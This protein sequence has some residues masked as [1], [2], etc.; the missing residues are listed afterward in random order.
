[1]LHVLKDCRATRQAPPVY[2]SSS[3]YGGN[4]KI[5]VAVEDG[6]DH[7]VSLCAATEWATEMM[8]HAYAGLYGIVVTG[9]SRR[10]RPR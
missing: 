3:A 8:A 10:H 7:P 5:P 6:A 9:A 2:A 1:L 4:R